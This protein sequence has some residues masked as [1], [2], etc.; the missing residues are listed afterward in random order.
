MSTQ[1]PSEVLA[2]L[3]QGIDPA[4]GEDLEATGIWRQA[5]VI[6][7]L[8]AGAAA[9]EEHKP[10]VRAPNSAHVGQPWTSQE[11]HDLLMAFGAGTPLPDIASRHQRS[12]TAIEARL[13]RLGKLTAGQRVTRNR[14]TAA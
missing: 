13:E 6:E 7:A 4:S 1:S 3:A 11:E 10:H 12:L 5:N 8:R 2:A 9:L 14:F